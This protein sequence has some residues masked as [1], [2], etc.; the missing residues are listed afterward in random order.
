MIA[1][2]LAIV[3]ATWAGMVAEH[4]RP[5][6][7]G[8][9]SRR[10]LTVVLYTVLPPV[11]FFNLVTADLD[12]SFAVAVVLSW[13]SVA[14]CAGLAYLIGDR[15]LGL[16]R[17]QTGSMM[18]GVLVANTGYLGYPLVAALL[19]FDRLGEAVAYDVAVSTTCLLVGAFAVGA[20]FGTTAGVGARE[21]ARSFF[22][23]NIPLYAAIAAL[24]APEWMA[25]DVLVDASRVAIIALLPLG[26]FAVG[27]A[28]AEDEDR[29]VH[30]P[31]PLDRPVAAVI[32]LKVMLM[33]ALLYLMALPLIDLPSSFLLLAAMPSGLNAMVVVHTFGLDLRITAGALVWTTALVVP[34]ALVASLL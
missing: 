19:G 28:L 13:I 5:G 3:V 18:T 10:A 33:P 30:F 15:V 23:R 29:G 12:E 1:I 17:P 16:S 34:V 27:A 32:G 4:R 14:I 11:I 20:A 7:A 6:V 25:P 26:F 22:A 24:V 21:R 8:H 2:T 31:P 9:G